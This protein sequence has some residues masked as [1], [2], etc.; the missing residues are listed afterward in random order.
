MEPDNAQSSHEEPTDAER[1][2]PEGAGFAIVAGL[3]VL[4]LLSLAFVLLR[5]LSS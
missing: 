5:S 3:V 4:T 2:V 1:R